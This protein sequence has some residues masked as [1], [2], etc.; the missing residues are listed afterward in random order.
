MILRLMILRPTLTYFGA[1]TL[2]YI[3]RQQWGSWGGLL[4]P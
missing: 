1:F 2:E 4:L 3:C